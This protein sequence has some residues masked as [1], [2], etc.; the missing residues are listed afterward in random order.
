MVAG[1]ASRRARPIGVLIIADV[2]LYR[3]GL[4]ASLASRDHLL[5]VAT[6]ASRPDALAK[7]REVGAD[8]AVIDMA[9]RESL[10]LIADL[11]REAPSTKILAFGVDE[12]ASDIIECA[13]A[14]A[15]GYVTADASI[16][17]LVTAIERI[18]REELVCSP[19]VAATLFQ[20]VSEGSPRLVPGAHGRTLTSR[21]RQVLRLM[22]Q[23]HS[24]KEIAQ[25]LNIAEPTVKNHVHH[26]LEKLDVSTRAQAVA[27]AAMPGS[28]RRTFGL[29]K[30]DKQETG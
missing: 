30:D 24:N 7:I 16:E 3:E 8:V 17:E 13:E 19:R 15:A 9:I 26:L 28:R 21:E 22:Q 5:I 6:S 2:R 18:F 20:R 29:T 1:D 14:G 10:D 25:G 11:R 4:A 23:G 12:V 27:R